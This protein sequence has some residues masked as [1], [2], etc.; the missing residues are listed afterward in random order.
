MSASAP[1]QRIRWDRDECAERDFTHCPHEDPY[2]MSGALEGVVCCLCGSRGTRMH[3]S[4]A[5]WLADGS[6]FARR[7]P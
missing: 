1:G 4:Y 7:A 6:R 2:A 3:G 5:P